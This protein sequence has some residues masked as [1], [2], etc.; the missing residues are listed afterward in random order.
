MTLHGRQTFRLRRK[1]QDNSLAAVKRLQPGHPVK[2]KEGGPC[3]P[4]SPFRRA[5]LSLAFALRNY[6]VQLEDWQEHRNDDAAYDHTK[7]HNQERLD[8]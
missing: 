8:Q 1:G 7:E 6:F 4:P 5:S 3:D 2:N